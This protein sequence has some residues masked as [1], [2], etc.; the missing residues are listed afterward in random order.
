MFSHLAFI[1]NSSDRQDYQHAGLPLPSILSF[2]SSPFEVFLKNACFY[3]FP[4]AKAAK[5]QA[6]KV[7]INSSLVEDIISLEE[8]KEDM[9]AVLTTLK[10]DFSRNL[11]IRTSPGA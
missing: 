1:C 8:V 9:A 3:I 10:D 2:C 4:S 7:N 11:S 5:G 6:S